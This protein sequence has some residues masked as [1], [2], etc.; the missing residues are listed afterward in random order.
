MTGIF[1]LVRR[2]GAGPTEGELDRL[3]QIVAGHRL[4]AVLAPVDTTDDLHFCAAGRLDGRRELERELGHDPAQ[5]GSLGDPAMMLAAYRRWGERAPEHLSGDWRLAAW[6]PRQRRLFMARDPFGHGSLLYHLDG[7]T[8]AFA[9]TLPA[10]LAPQPVVPQ[11]NELYLAQYLISWPAYHGPDTIFAASPAAG[12]RARAQRLR[13][14]RAYALLPAI[15]L[16]RPARARRC[17]RAAL[18]C[19]LPALVRDRGRGAGHAR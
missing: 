7:H 8:I 12:A 13:R 16:R 9:P 11:L 10:L 1:G 2:D 4:A 19:R 3:R 6:R 14:G 15:R 18:R 17:A 5:V